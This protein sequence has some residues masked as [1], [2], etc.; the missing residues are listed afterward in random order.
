MAARVRTYGAIL[1]VGVSGTGSE[2]ERRPLQPDLP[3][4][5]IIFV[6]EGE[7]AYLDD[8]TWVHSRG[9]LM[10]APSGLP[11]RVRFTSA[12]KFV[13]AR[14]PRA[15]LLPFV[16]MLTDEVRIFTE[17]TVLE[18]AMEGFLEQSV[19][20]HQQVTEGDSHTVNRVVLEMAGAMLRERQGETLAPAS[21]RV[22]L[23]NRVMAEIANNSGDAR[24]DS[25]WLA[26]AGNVSLRYLQ[27]VFAATGT[28]VAG[29]IRRERARTARSAL[30]DP[31]FDD[32]SIEDVSARSGFGSSASM[33]R[34]LE[35]VYHLTATELRSQRG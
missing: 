29:E 12:W 18:R 24:L 22:A 20:S 4:I 15:A 23:R 9:P 14:V 28:T 2:F 6:Q 21:P 33:R 34:A 17:P 7:F 30:Q 3:T 16:P 27:S 35:D 5:D 11:S 26:N 19:A 32:L 31:R 25:V 13:V 1:V 10:I 8:G